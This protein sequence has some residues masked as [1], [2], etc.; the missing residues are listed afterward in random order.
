MAK[1]LLIDSL[2]IRLSVEESREGKTIARGEFARCDTPTQNGR[3]YPRKIYE[4]EVGKLK[5]SIERR[6]GFGE[7]DHPADGKTKLSRASHIITKLD[8]DPDGKVVGE[9]EILDTPNG[10][11]LKAILAAGAEVGVSSRGF[12]ST[13]NQ[14]GTQMVGEDFVLRTFDFV[15]DP[16][17]KTAYPEIFAEDVE[18]QFNATTLQ[19]EFPELV[20][21]LA[22][23]IKADLSED[24][25]TTASAAVEQALEQHTDKVREEMRESFE[26]T[27]AKQLAEMREDVG[28]SLRE[29]YE[30]DPQRAGAIGVLGQIGELVAEF[31]Q[32]VGEDAY[33]DAIKA[34]DIEM[35]EQAERLEKMEALARS[36]G[37][38]L[39][40]EREIAG[41]PLAGTVRNVMRDAGQMESLDAVKEKLSGVLADLQDAAAAQHQAEEA[42]AR[43]EFTTLEREHEAY[44]RNA[45]SWK[46][47]GDEHR[48]QLSGMKLKVAS[49]E[50]KLERAVEIGEALEAKVQQAEDAAE[51]AMVQAYKAESVVGFSNSNNLMGLLENVNDKDAID[52]IV[53]ENGNHRMQ[54]SRLEEAR[55]TLRRGTANER[56]AALEEEQNGQLPNHSVFQDMSMSKMRELAGIKLSK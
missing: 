7:L 34:K 29:E 23:D 1:E 36:A 44:V 12:G 28:R 8:I 45:E 47:E 10:R 20:Q 54:S 17:M 32:P 24:A 33:R 9:A 26:R 38:Q 30:A 52:R 16:A 15:A 21:Q 41:H 40:V 25:Q 13:V 42:E 53:H 50:K 3:T 14:N 22:E 27:L 5:E 4:R 2:P 51:E 35:A 39:F 46:Q 11:T 56:P 6:R 18:Y 19:N 31:T 48:E 49:L 55:K 43:A 37:Y